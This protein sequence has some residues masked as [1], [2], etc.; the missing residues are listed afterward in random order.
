MKLVAKDWSC[1]DIS[2]H[3]KYF[4]F[5]WFTSVLVTRM[6]RLENFT[7][8]PDLNLERNSKHRGKDKTA[9]KVSLKCSTIRLQSQKILS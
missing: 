9:W 8:V 7:K 2:P 5:R 3:D 6:K 1:I 4:F